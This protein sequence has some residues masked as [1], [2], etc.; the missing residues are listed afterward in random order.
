MDISQDVVTGMCAAHSTR[1]PTHYW[2]AVQSGHRWKPGEWNSP[3]LV[4]IGVRWS[5]W[6]VNSPSSCI[7]CGSMTLSSNGVRREQGH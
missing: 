2:H 4:V 6:P 7:A 3:K 1:P 5:P